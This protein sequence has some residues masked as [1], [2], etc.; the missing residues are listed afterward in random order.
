MKQA[1]KWISAISLVLLCAGC[2]PAP[3]YKSQQDLYLEV[4]KRIKSGQIKTLGEVGVAPLGCCTAT[5]P[6]DLRKASS[7]GNVYVFRPATNQLIVIFKTW[8]GKGFN[9]E[10]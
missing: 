7:D 2:S 1:L 9:L 3:K 5:L 4:I 6:P 10:G 8:T